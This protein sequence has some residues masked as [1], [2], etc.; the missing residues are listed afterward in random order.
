VFPFPPSLYCYLSITSFLL[1]SL[2]FSILPVKP[3]N[4]KTKTYEMGTIKKLK[5]QGKNYQ[6][7]AFNRHWV[8]WPFFLFFFFF[9]RFIL[10][11]PYFLIGLPR[12]SCLRFRKGKGRIPQ[13]ILLLSALSFFI[14]ILFLRRFSCLR[15]AVFAGT[16]CGGL[17]FNSTC[18]DT[19]LYSYR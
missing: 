16:R 9:S 2:H 7:M 14:F 10:I 13:R 4:K 12:D 11:S 6:P 19:V 17:V 18:T 5:K 1:F 15:Y 8:T 3:H